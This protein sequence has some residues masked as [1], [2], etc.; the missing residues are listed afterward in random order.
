MIIVRFIYFKWA[1]SSYKPRKSLLPTRTKYPTNHF[2]ISFSVFT[3][4]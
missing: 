2:F 1:S 3:E 4:L